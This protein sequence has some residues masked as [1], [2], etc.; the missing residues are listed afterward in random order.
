MYNCTAS[1]GGRIYLF[2]VTAALS[3]PQD[4]ACESEK[5]D[6]F[7]NDGQSAVKA[8]KT[9]QREISANMY[10]LFYTLM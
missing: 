5:C 2:P 3:V 4:A 6:L 9:Q 8:T 7:T 10:L 1:T